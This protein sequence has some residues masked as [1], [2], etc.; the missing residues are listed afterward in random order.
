MTFYTLL[1]STESNAD[2]VVYSSH[3]FEHLQSLASLVGP[4]KVGSSSLPS[5]KV[6][7]FV[8]EF[9][10][11]IHLNLKRGLVFVKELWGC[12]GIRWQ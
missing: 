3:G 8:V 11:P 4:V 1:P 2:Q 9:R 6:F 10:N 12:M 7:L 5:S